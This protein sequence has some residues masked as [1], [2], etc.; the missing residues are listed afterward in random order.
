MHSA[1]KDTMQ[2]SIVELTGSTGFI[3][4][5]VNNLRDRFAEL[6]PSHKEGGVTFEQRYYVVGEN[7]AYGII[8]GDSDDVQALFVRRFSERSSYIRYMP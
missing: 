8:S 1:L 5:L 7:K 2:R 3:K 4:S 6:V